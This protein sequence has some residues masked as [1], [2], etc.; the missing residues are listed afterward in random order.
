MLCI[1][2]NFLYYLK[3][4]YFLFIFQIMVSIFYPNKAALTHVALT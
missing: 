2:G 4:K 3:L 1:L